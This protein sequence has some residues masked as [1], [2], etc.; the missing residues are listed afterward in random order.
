MAK[1]VV[2]GNIFVEEGDPMTKTPDKLSSAGGEMKVTKIGV[3][4]MKNETPDK[5]RE[6]IEEA[7]R[8]YGYSWGS[9]SADVDREVALTHAI[10]SIEEL[11][12]EKKD[13]EVFDGSPSGLLADLRKPQDYERGWNACL[14]EIRKR[15]QESKE[16]K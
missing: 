7:C 16:G 5:L 9:A 2:Y 3:I 1:V 13:I 6:I 10:K 4:E 14:D 11:L 12:P 8:K 15:W